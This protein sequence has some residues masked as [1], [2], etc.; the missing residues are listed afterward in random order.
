MSNL[1]ARLDKLY[2]L[3][4]RAEED[5]PIILVWS[6]LPTDK[7]VDEPLKAE[8]MSKGFVPYEPHV[9]EPKFSKASTLGELEKL[10]RKYGYGLD[11][12]PVVKLETVENMWADLL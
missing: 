3:V 2:R 1:K 7:P 9:L 5:I 10:C 12:M 8:Y 11:I 6:T 4:E